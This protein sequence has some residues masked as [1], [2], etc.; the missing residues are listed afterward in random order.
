MAR[1]IHFSTPLSNDLITVSIE[2]DKFEDALQ[3]LIAKSESPF[4]FETH[5]FTDF[6]TFMDFSNM[7][8]FTENEATVIVSPANSKGGAMTRQEIF[9]F[10][11][12]SSGRKD[13]FAA[14]CKDRANGR[15]YTNI[16]NQ[17][18][19]AL[20]EDCFN[21]T[22]SISASPVSPVSS[23]A[24]I[25]SMSFLQKVAAIEE[26]L[27]SLDHE[28]V[29]AVVDVDWDYIESR[30]ECAI[31]DMAQIRDACGSV[32]DDASPLALAAQRVRASH[33]RV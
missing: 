17:E 33:F 31:D 12:E 1:T 16:S 26:L 7:S 18:V 15:H 22:A 32:S 19:V 30:I 20:F 27:E 9:A 11:N 3:A 4:S 25:E 29:P 8:L 2:S 14:F 10:L 23:T 21:T 28:D 13:R 6:T 24:G 5:V